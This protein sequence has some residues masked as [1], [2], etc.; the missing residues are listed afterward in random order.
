[1]DPRLPELVQAAHAAMRAGRVDEAA[2]IWDSV[3]TLA[4]HH[5]QALLHAGQ[6]AHMRKDMGRA[7]LLLERAAAADPR[8]PIVPL[9]Q[10]FACRSLGDAVGELAALERAL[11]IDPYFYPALLAKGVWL[12]R[13]GRKRLAARTYR[14]MLTILPSESPRELQTQIA[15]ARDV[16]RENAEELNAQLAPLLGE[17]R[18]R[19]AGDKFAR[20][21]ACKDAMIEG[22]RIFVQQ[23]T[24]LHFPRLPAIQF[25]DNADFPWLRDVEAATDT[26][27]EELAALVNA[28]SAGFA[29]YVNHPEG[30]PINQWAEL[31]HSPRWSAYFL[32][33]DGKRLDDH[34]ARCPKTAAIV[35]AAP[36]A[37]VP[38]FAPAVFFSTLEPHTRI[39]PHT[40]VTNTRLIVHVPLIVPEKCG[41]RVGS[42]IREWKPGKAFVFDD[43][44]EHEAWN[45]S[46]YT[47]VILIFD[48]WNPYLS[49][50]ERELVCA[51]LNGVRD[52]YGEDARA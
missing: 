1:M 19:H 23:P 34:C 42:E 47:R 20:F 15:H 39:P 49:A 52:Y 28:D 48:I 9:N 40:G 17:I 35:E 16:V 50:A 31:N 2:R 4:P 51:L 8:N 22:K 27:R 36:I 5:P 25:Y 41:F 38:G 43:T 37:D 26:I 13:S 18:A 21:D 45:E 29:P 30:V 6:H 3:L 24:M 46:D 11:A 32:W 33:Q 7:R 44:I 12:E 10:A 14:D